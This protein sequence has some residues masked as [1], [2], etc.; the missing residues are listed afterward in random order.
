LST[1][2]EVFV[3][4]SGFF[5]QLV[6]RD[7]RH[8]QAVKLLKQAAARQQ[9]LVTTDHILD[10]TATLLKARGHGHL[11]SRWIDAVTRS[12]VYRVEWTDSARFERVR[13]FF[14]KHD[15]QP[16]SFTD[17]VSFCTM[18]E[19]RLRDALTKDAHFT[20]AGFR[21]LLCE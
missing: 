17:C 7:D 14:L 15:D 6:Q 16:W 2:R 5:A 13:T 8:K 20:A 4:T 10:E 9:I 19:L 1:A 21:A 18:Q 12:S 3:D 11:I